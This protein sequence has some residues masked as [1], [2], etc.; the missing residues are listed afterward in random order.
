MS[1][2]GDTYLTVQPPGAAV[3][4]SSVDRS[5]VIKRLGTSDVKDL[6]KNNNLHVMVD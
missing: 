6:H 4:L 2:S 1:L 5:A 3:K